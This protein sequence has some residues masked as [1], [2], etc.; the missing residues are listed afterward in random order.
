MVIGENADPVDLP[1]NVCKKNH[2]TNV[3]ASQ[4]PMSLDE[5]IE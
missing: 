4:R 3:R 1:I 5:A 2:L